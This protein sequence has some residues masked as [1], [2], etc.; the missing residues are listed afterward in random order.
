MR[1]Y[2][3]SFGRSG[4]AVLVYR[5]ALNPVQSIFLIPFSFISFFLKMNSGWVYRFQNLAVVFLQFRKRE[6]PMYVITV[7]KYLPKSTTQN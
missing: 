7:C 2:D 5:A 1:P 6:Y 4:S 3:I